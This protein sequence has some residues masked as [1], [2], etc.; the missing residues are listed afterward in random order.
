MNQKIK[1]VLERIEKES[2][3]QENPNWIISHETGEFL[4]KLVRENNFK[5]VL[6]VGT[7]IGYSSI[8]LAE[9]LSRIG[10]KLYTIESNDER[11]TVATENFMQ[12]GL[13]NHIQQIK[14]HAPDVE[15]PDMFNFL[16]LDATKAEYISYIKTFLFHMKKGGMIVAD[17]ALSHAEELKEYKDYI[18]DS[19]QLESELK[20]IGTGV[21]VS[22]I[23]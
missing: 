21:F 12:A 15:I 7:S 23:V 6:E 1:E 3:E 22:K 18:F 13:S 19:P 5:T 20:K 8:W 14:G 17:N 11:Y 10:G 2:Q 16:F 4:N 9:A